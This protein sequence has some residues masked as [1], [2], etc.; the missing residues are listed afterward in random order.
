MKLITPVFQ[1][2]GKRKKLI[3][4]E[5]SYDGFVIGRFDDRESARAALDAY[6][7]EALAI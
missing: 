4:F 1:T 2:I 3:G 5:A 7:Y 6:V